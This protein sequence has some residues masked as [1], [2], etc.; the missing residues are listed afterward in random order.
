MHALPTARS[1]VLVGVA[2]RMARIECVS[3]SWRYDYYTEGAIQ[4]GREEGGRA[5]EN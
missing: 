4:K 2:I 3:L 1:T 5:E